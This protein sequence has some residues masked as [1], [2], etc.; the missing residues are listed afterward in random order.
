[1][2]YIDILFEKGLYNQ[3]KKIK[4]CKNNKNLKKDEKK[5]KDKITFDEAI[6][7]YLN[8]QKDSACFRKFKMPS[9]N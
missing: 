7:T 6:E 9:K 3:C 5:N 2:D 1:M 8:N 4:I